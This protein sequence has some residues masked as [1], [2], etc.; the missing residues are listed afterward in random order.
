MHLPPLFPDRWRRRLIADWR[1]SWRLWSIQISALGTLLMAS[2]TALPAEFRASLPHGEWVA[3]GLF[4]LT[5]TTRL[6]DQSARQP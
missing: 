5:F 3:A 2:W 1:K 4:L 6:I